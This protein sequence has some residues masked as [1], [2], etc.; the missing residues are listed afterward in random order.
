MSFRILVGIYCQIIPTQTPQRGYHGVTEAVKTANIAKITETCINCTSAHCT[1]SHANPMG[2]GPGNTF[3]A[4]NRE[5]QK[6]EK[7]YCL[8]QGHLADNLL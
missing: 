5:K 6:T 7:L 1:V 2:W 8:W 4:Q 3:W